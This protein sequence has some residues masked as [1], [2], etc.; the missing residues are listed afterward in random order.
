MKLSHGTTRKRHALVDTTGL[1]LNVKVLPANI[2][3]CK[4]N[5]LLLNALREDF[6]R[7][8]RIWADQG[9]T[10]EFKGWVEADLGLTF[11]VVYPWWR[12]IERYLPGVYEQQ[13]TG[14][15]I[16][17]RRLYDEQTFV[18]WTFQRR[19]NRDYELIAGTTECFIYVAMIRLMVR[20]LAS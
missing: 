8:R 9:C 6:P 1:L 17:P 15:K 12:Q 10:G 16:I 13:A 19:L 11:E 14:F 4:G 5:R 7:F 20:R 18:G 2:N 3:D